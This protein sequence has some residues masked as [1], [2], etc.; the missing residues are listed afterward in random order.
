V[1]T[2][3]GTNGV[4]SFSR[5]FYYWWPSPF[6]GFFYLRRFYV[7]APYWSDHDIRKEGE[8]SYEIF[9][10]G[11]SSYDDMLLDRV[12]TYLA[13][14]VM[15]NFTGTFMILAEWRDVHPYPH[16]SSYS[17]FSYY[18]PSLNSFT[19]QVYNAILFD[20][21]YRWGNKLSLNENILQPDSYV[22]NY[23]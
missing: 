22:H 18:Y 11:R 16:G 3:V 19:R 23:T 21:I 10:K 1:Y 20:C 14:N 7:V 13:A 17:Y 6:P 9:E 12:N 15:T 4:I 5:P 2:Q 8:V